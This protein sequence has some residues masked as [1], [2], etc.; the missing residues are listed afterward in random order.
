VSKNVKYIYW[1]DFKYEEL[2]DLR[3]D[4]VEERNLA[5]EAAP[6]KMLADLRGRFA[7][8]KRQAK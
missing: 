2:V 5:R 8:L 6:A 1:P 7:E 4:P 3:Q